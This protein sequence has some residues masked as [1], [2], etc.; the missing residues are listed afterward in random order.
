MASETDHIRMANRNHAALM[1][2]LPSID[3]FGEWVVT[4][5][6]YKAVHVVEAAFANHSGIHSS[7]HM[8]REQMLKCVPYK[9]LFKDYIALSNVSRIARYLI[10]PHSNFS[11]YLDSAGIRNLIRDRLHP[12][13]QRAL[14]FLSDAEKANLRK[15]N[16]TDFP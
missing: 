1:H 6:F 8:D 4:V 16:T 11:D 7:T 13:E 12:L 2:L 5:A 14:G 10:G 9:P 15:I 3:E